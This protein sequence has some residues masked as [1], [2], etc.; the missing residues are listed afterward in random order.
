[1]RYTLF[2]GLFPPYCFRRRLVALFFLLFFFLLL[3]LFV[4]LYFLDFGLALKLLLGII[5]YPPIITLCTM[6]F[7][8][9]KK[10]IYIYCIMATR[11]NTRTKKPMRRTRKSPRKSK[12][13]RKRN[14]IRKRR[15]RRGRRGGSRTPT[16]M[17]VPNPEGVGRANTA[18]NAV[19]TDVGNRYAIGWRWNVGTTGFVRDGAVNPP[20]IMRDVI[21]GN[22][23]MATRSIDALHDD[24][25]SRSE[26][27]NTR[28]PSGVTPLM[29][30]VYLQNPSM[31]RFLL[32]NRANVNDTIHIMRDNDGQ[33]L[34]TVLDLAELVSTDEI[35]QLLR[36]I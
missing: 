17:N 19:L 24:Y 10:I 35:V 25:T 11:R 15:S 33:V 16:P 23:E 14:A 22:V 31:V 29:I 1:M 3:P 7:P 28:L 20:D 8:W 21:A 18:M 27:V 13:S 30:A 36:D 9:T 26:I 4:L 5:M 6:A 2:G 34:T 32:G 12:R